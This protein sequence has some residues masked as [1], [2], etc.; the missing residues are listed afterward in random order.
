MQR[1]YSKR[2]I[3]AAAPLVLALAGGLVGCG[4]AGGAEET[5]A[6]SPTPVSSEPLEDPS[7]DQPEETVAPTEAPPST[8]T[9]SDPAQS[10]SACIV[11]RWLADNENMSALF[12]EMIDEDGRLDIEEIT[13]AAITEF[14]A[15]GEFSVEYSAWTITASTP[16]GKMQIER[17]GTDRGS[18]VADDQGT[19]IMTDEEMGAIVTL[20][21]GPMKQTTPG[22]AQTINAAYVCDGDLLTVTSEGEVSRLD[23]M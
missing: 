5:P 3:L 12:A 19:L 18:Y 11:G 15:S 10:P 13:G 9:A 8:E 14:G 6:L 7:T 1:T 20:S 4:E 2:R 23:R 21:M 16:Q 22:V 17:E